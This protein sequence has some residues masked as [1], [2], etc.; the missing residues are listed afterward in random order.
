MRSKLGKTITGITVMLLLSGRP[1]FAQNAQDDELVGVMAGY[2]RALE[3]AEDS[4]ADTGQNMEASLGWEMLYGEEDF[5]RL[6]FNKFRFYVAKGDSGSDYLP[7][8][9]MLTLSGSLEIG[10]KI[11]GS[12]SVGGGAAVSSVS[13]SDYFP[14]GEKNTGKVAVNNRPYNGE[15]FGKFVEKAEDY[16]SEKR[17]IDTEMESLVVFLAILLAM[18][19]TDLNEK[20]RESGTPLA[21]IPPVGIR[22][23]NPERTFTVVTLENGIEMDYNGYAP[24]QYSGSPVFPVLDGKL[25]MKYEIKDNSSVE[26]VT[27]DG[28]IHARETSFV[29]S[30]RFNSCRM[31]NMDNKMSEEN[32]SGNIVINGNSYS[33][34]SLLMAGKNWF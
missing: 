25:T 16:V 8:G 11:N 18:D 33:F 31:S 26:S 3:R 23:F 17:I 14:Y 30:L 20:I 19:E 6:S 22:A 24:E 10:E 1:L 13:F 7:A 9:S 34:Q 12:L 21:D 4:D 5:L 27:F 15:N 29:S 28:S 32:L 2:F